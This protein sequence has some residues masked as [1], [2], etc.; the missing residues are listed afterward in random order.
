MLVRTTSGILV[1]I[2]AIFV[3][4][5]KK[6][7][8][9]GNF[10]S[11]NPIPSQNGRELSPNALPIATGIITNQVPKFES[12]DIIRLKSGSLL[13]V[14]SNEYYHGDLTSVYACTSN[15]DGLTWSS[16]QTINM[17]NPNQYKL[18]NVNI[19][20]VDSRLFLVIQRTPGRP[21]EGG[22]P[23]ITRS[24]DNGF[25][26]TPPELMLNIPEKRFVIINS[27]N[28]TIT[29]TG[30]IIVPVGY[31]Q[32]NKV[33]ILYSDNNGFNW[34]EGPNAIGIS[35]GQFGEPTIARLT[36][37]R[38]MMLIRTCLNW[39]YQSYSNDDG[40][41]WSAPVPTSLQSP[42]A[43][44]AIKTTS[45]GYI[46]AVFTNSPNIGSEP[47]YPRNNLTIGVSLDN[48]RSWDQFTTII[49]HTDPHYMVMEPSITFIR[50]KIL[51]SYLHDAA[52]G[53]GTDTGR[54]ISTA[55]YNKFDIIIG[56]RHEW[57]D[58]YQWTSNGNGT[59]E[60]VN[61]DFLHLG[62]STNTI[63]SVYKEMNISGAYA[64]EF[65]AKV[66]NF[67][68]PGY[69]NN[70]STLGTKV[71]NGFYRFIMK[72]ESDGIYVVNASGDWKKYAP[73]QWL[74]SI[75]EWH[76]WKAVVS[77]SIAEVYMDDQLIIPAYTLQPTN[78]D[79]RLEHWTNSTSGMPTNCLIDY[80]YYT[81]FDNS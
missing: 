54:T 36:D 18:L 46:V 72:L 44:H 69:N 63:A 10:A 19:F 9:F 74:N 4:A 41:T 5:C 52:S 31:E 50:D 16:P 12:A 24:D 81:P 75:K 43:A 20:C 80:T 66:L 35:D 60:I 79:V 58:F 15:D 2:I 26:W 21:A 6:N 3:F 47:G 49:D 32:V 1:G 53:R 27:R 29:K 7:D 55:L 13:A 30:R 57:K 34:T 42:W 28:I 76:V 78:A 65:K 8:S 25:T 56:L 11:P 73:T 70:Y 39:I 23:L 17:P 37:G 40:I 38:L 62:D 45:E 48:G 71:G 51:I 68:D 67:A 22:I 14:L 64:L 77:N 59:R 33:G 61:G